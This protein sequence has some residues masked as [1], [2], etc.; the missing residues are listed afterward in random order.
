[1]DVSA[2]TVSRKERGDQPVTMRDV[3]GM[4][5]VKDEALSAERLGN[6]YG[7]WVAREPKPSYPFAGPPVIHDMLK[8]FEREA[9]KLGATDAELDLIEALLRS[10]PVSHYL[11]TGNSA[12]D[13]ADQVV[14]L[15]TLIG[16][17]RSWIVALTAARANVAGAI[18]PHTPGGA[19]V[20]PVTATVDPTAK[21]GTAEALRKKK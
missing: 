13:V 2:A 14:K 11:R 7:G 9:N 8:S 1:M 16:V 3:A 15:D 18:R 5:R 21:Q 12:K 6:S 4:E 17:F 20:A 19:P 10:P